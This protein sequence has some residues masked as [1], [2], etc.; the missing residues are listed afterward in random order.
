MSTSG[1]SRRTIMQSAALLPLQAIRSSAQNS[2][3]RIGVVGVGNRGSYE[4]K[5][6]TKDPRV[7][8]AAVCDISDDALG[9]ASTYAPDAKQ[10]KDHRDLLSSKDLDAVII[11]TPV[12]L[13]PDHFEAAVKSGKHIYMEKP[14]GV[15]VA[16]CKRVI[17]VADGADRKINISFGF[18]QRYG[19]VYMNA[20][21]MLDS[22]AIGPVREV[23][24]QFLKYALTGDE[25]V[26]PLPK[27]DKEKMEQWKLWRATFGEVIVE[28]YCHNL[29]AVNWFMNGHPV[30]ALGSG[31]RTVEK[32]GDLMDHLSV[33]YDYPGNVQMTLIG[34]QQTP[35]FFR[36]NNERFIGSKGVIET[37][38]EY[39][40]YNIGKGMVTEKSEHDI[41]ID[42]LQAFVTR[43][44]E[45]KP[46]NTAIRGAESTL[47]AILGQQAC[48]KKREV[49]WDEMM[50]L[51]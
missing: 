17:R 33:T 14:A 47:T 16:D 29:D 35:K 10:Y 22:G 27:N 19:P 9:K 43:I 41:T 38:R 34:S 50:R 23:H 48:D 37:A 4:A 36:A 1:I 26:P 24:V 6:I 13:H 7:K 32:R 51:G 11:A 30:K 25:P 12:F 31:G 39:W 5:T 15:S 3:I 2:A 28:T 45:N 21:K 40:S 46:E 42:S 8:L 18:Q 49:T 20:K 44:I